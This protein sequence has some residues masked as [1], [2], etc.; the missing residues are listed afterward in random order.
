MRPARAALL[1]LLVAQAG[2]AD[3]PTQPVSAAAA[4][5]SPAPAAS[6]SPPPAPPAAPPAFPAGVL[7]STLRTA[8]V[9]N[10]SEGIDAVDLATG[11]VVWSTN[12]AQVPL[13]VAGDRLYA[14]A[15]VKRNRLRILALDL[16]R[17]GECVL[18]SD[19]IVLPR[20]VVTGEAP[21][22]SFRSRWRLEK[23]QLVLAWEASAWTEATAQF[24]E[25][26]PGSRKQA[27]GVARV[28]LEGGQVESGPPEKEEEPA[29]P[30]LP[31]HLDKLA[32][33]WH[34]AMGRYL[35]AVILEEVERKPDPAANKYP[36]FA[37]APREDGAGGSSAVGRSDAGRPA[38]GRAEARR[39]RR[40]RQQ[41]LMVRAWD[42]LTGKPAS[43]RELLRGQRLVVQ[44]SLDKGHLWLRD[45]APSPEEM[46][47]S[48]ARKGY[49]WS[50]FSIAKGEFVGRVPFV[51][52]TQGITVVGRRAYYLVAG[53]LSGP[54][55]RPRLRDRYL[56]AVDLKSGKRVWEHEV[57]GKYLTPP[58]P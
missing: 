47:T 34:G 13:L 50:V 29:T 21:G 46:V 42:W 54:V 48:E 14:Q 57:A 44:L 39:G 36:G 4:P 43:P 26:D 53:P 1:L 45:A 19:P 49:D 28:D 6:P 51:P 3:P 56:Y 11:E 32:V 2:R 52:G 7:D 58:R 12:E 15:G 30:R 10:A 23:N 27:A 38:L 17:K 55:D 41:A 20:W 9:A 24:P 8:Y 37:A 18:E 16:T 33:R 35:V 31:R 22:H 5:A 40:P 25:R